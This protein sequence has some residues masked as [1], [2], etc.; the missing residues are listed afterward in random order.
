VP[1]LLSLLLQLRV[2]AISSSCTIAGALPWP[3]I[4]HN[5]TSV[6]VIIV[7][8][9]AVVVVVVVVLIVSNVEG[10]IIVVIQH[11][12]KASKSKFSIWRKG[13]NKTMATSVVY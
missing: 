9:I 11:N 5:L 8:V 3:P 7:H 13:A 2:R 12:H 1:P 4:N 6:L 10:L